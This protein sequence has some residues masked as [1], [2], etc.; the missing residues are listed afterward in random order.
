MSK[1]KELWHRQYLPNSLEHN[2]NYNLHIWVPVLT[3][4]GE[5]EMDRFITS[6]EELEER[7]EL[8]DGW[9]WQRFHLIAD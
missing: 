8:A 1:A 3:K 5:V 9:K 2:K 7:D 6:E 4:T